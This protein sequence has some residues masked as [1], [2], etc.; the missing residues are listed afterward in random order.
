MTVSA[1]RDDD[2]VDDTAMLSHSA[3]GADYGGVRAL[4]LSVTVRDNSVRGVTVSETALSFRETGRATYT[5]VLDTQPTGTVTVRPMVTGDDS[6]QISPASLS[7]T[8]SNWNRPKTV[9]VSAN[10]DIDQDDESATIAHTVS[11]ADYGEENVPAASVSVTVTD[12]DVPSEEVRLSLST[13]SVP[14]DGGPRRIT[15]TGELDAAPEPADDV[16]VTLTLTGVTATAGEDFEAVSPVTLTIPAGQVRAT[17]LFTL[18]PMRDS[19]DEDDETVQL[20]V[21]ITAKGSGSSIDRAVPDTLEV[22]IT[23]NDTRGV[24]VT[25]LELT[26]AEGLSGTYT[27]KLNSAPTA[28]VA[29][30]PS[31]TGN[32]DAR[33]VSFDPTSLAFTA[34]NWNEAR[35]MTV[36]VAETT[37]VQEDLEVTISHTVSG[38][39]YG[40]ES[41]DYSVP[42][43]RLSLPG[44]V[45]DSGTNKVTS[46]VPSA[47]GE[48]VVRG[49]TAVDGTRI[50]LDSGQSAPTISI[51]AVPESD[52][53]LNNPPRG[54]SA[55]DTVV[56]IELEGDATLNGTATV[57]LPIRGGGRG[58]VF[59]YDETLS[60]WVQLEEPP[61]GSPAGLACGVTDKFSYFASTTKE[62]TV[63]AKAWLARFGRTLSEHVIDAVHDR[64]TAPR[65]AG[66]SGTLAG[67]ALPRP[68][69][70][71]SGLSDASFLLPGPDAGFG[72]D[73]GSIARGEGA[74]V[75]SRRLTA[76][77]L[78]TGSRFS[79]TGEEVGGGFVTLWG[80]GAATRFDAGSGGAS[81]DGRVTT[82]LLGG[83]WASDRLLAG[84]A[85]SL[86]EGRGSWQEDDGRKVRIDSRMTGLH[87][88]FGYRV[89][90]GLSVWGA[91]GY[92]RG[93]LDLPENTGKIRTDI[94]MSMIAA[95]A[96][97]NLVSPEGIEGLSLAL[98]TDALFLRIGADRSGNLEEV[99]ADVSRLRLALEGSHTREMASGG[100]LTPSLELGLRHDGGDAETGF[101]ADIGAGLAWADADRGLRTEIRGRGLLTHEDGDFREHGVSGSFA[102]DADPY[103]GRG[104]SL[105]L[106]QSV[107]GASSGGSEALFSRGTMAGI[108]EEAGSDD[109]RFS[110]KL[111]YGLAA[112]SH[113]MTSTPEIGF[114]LTEASREYMLGWRLGLAARGGFS[115]GVEAVR[116]EAANDNDRAEHG[117]G[118]RLS[119]NW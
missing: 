44:L 112:F 13:D 5:V 115:L 107:G 103:P 105:S 20:G 34:S 17:A 29:V 74:P 113:R 104:L 49:G 72:A 18:T 41:P 38:G 48:L 43:V 47:G 66:F 33:T 110:A 96:K 57:C 114:G 16:S 27:V 65:R 86:S 3:S 82:G 70:L 14:E 40:S 25:P 102:W 55:G 92:G 69:G 98:K 61:G 15:V 50:T 24:T 60:E 36:K 51:E 11:G 58:F 76:R 46:R 116:R 90:N 119:L 6:I 73:A 85:L 77:D 30:T 101:G 28:E 10:D 9:T 45:F 35:T 37:A 91:A 75:R 117:L 93:E 32:T 83:D 26:V 54:F 68:G 118:L 78:L 2:A 108:E 109:R 8:A 19:V 88:Y 62:S 89:S 63:A 12:D 67:Q 80:R 95:G 4:P 59:R 94:D 21:A 106:T 81:L 56:N 100:T 52:Q 97:G 99:E 87:P 42:S 111:G 31:V 22:T 1:A 23:D 64:L 53:A 7:F 39:D 71:P 84:V 79:L